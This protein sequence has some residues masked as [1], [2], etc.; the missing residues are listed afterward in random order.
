MIIKLPNDKERVAQ[1]GRKLTEYKK[2]QI[3]QTIVEEVVLK[4]KY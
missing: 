4:Q 3:I 1:L 2:E